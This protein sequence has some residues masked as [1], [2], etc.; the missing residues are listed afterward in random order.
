M[1]KGNG[2]IVRIVKQVAFDVSTIDSRKCELLKK[3]LQLSA[4]TKI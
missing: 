4:F 3:G 1:G 2:A